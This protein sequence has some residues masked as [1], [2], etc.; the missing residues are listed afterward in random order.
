MTKRGDLIIL[1]NHRLYCGDSASVEDLDRLLDGARIHL[2]NTDPPYNVK[3]EPR[4][5]NAIA[6][7]CR[8]FPTITFSSGKLLNKT[9]RMEEG[10]AHQGLL[11]HQSFDVAR[12]G[13][14]KATGKDAGQG[15]PARR[16]TSFR[17]M[18]SKRC[19][20]AWFGNIARV[21]EPG[22]SLLHLGRLRQRR[23]TI[24]RR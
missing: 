4:S 13:K 20:A 17:T 18:P 1:G 2:V 11:H 8:R 21:L 7:G 15:P 6:A 23:P 12:Q 9:C 22:R 3:V 19:C 5:N 14:K 24:R 10:D 16:T